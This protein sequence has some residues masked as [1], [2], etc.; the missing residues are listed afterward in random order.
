MKWRYNQ[1]IKESVSIEDFE[2][3]IALLNRIAFDIKMLIYNLEILIL[4]QMFL[5]WMVMR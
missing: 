4:F 3:E 1:I 5:E 2:Q